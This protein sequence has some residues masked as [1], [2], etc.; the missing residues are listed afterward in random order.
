MI[1]YSANKQIFSEDIIS[2]TIESKIQNLMLL[3]GRGGVSKNEVS[4]WRNSLMYMNNV[5]Q[6]SEIPN[7]TGV[8][9]E[10]HI[11]NCSKR[12]DFII[13]GSDEDKKE[14]LVIVELKQWS[15]AKATSKPSIVS[16]FVGGNVREAP[17]PSYQAWS[18]AQ[19]I[20][21]FNQTVQ[22]EN[23]EVSPCAFLHNYQPDGVIDGP[24]YKED[25]AKAPVFLKQDTLKLREFIKKWIKYGDDKNL[26][27][28]IDQGK[29]R[30]SKSL[31]DHMVALLKGSQEF[32]MIDDQKI[33][34]ETA[35]RISAIVYQ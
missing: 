1:I 29:I 15:E 10:Y 26:L 9:I 4:S 16:T 3:K 8:S 2:G 32:V 11:P 30:P 27:F 6:D 35:C 28:R 22:D 25:C 13:S 17:H 5:M 34:Y 31:T 21:D 7:S 33:T 23:I 18:Y 19:L 24:I 14:N 20:K 12:I